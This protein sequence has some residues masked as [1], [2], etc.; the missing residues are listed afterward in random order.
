MPAGEAL[1]NV[2]NEPLVDLD[3]DGKYEVIVSG[4]HADGT[5][6]TH[7]L[8]AATGVEITKVD[9][10]GFVGTALLESPK[11]PTLLTFAAG[12]TTAWAYDGVTKKLV[13]RWTVNDRYPLTEPDWAH[14]HVA[15]AANTRPVDDRSRRRRDPRSDDWQDLSRRARLRAT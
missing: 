11:R 12:N 8:A 9:G 2:G 15:G 7:V 6:S 14:A 5:Y 4:H 13:K 10:E 1:S 3:G